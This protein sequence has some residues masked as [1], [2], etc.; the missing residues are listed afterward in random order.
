MT[1]TRSPSAAGQ[2]SASLTRKGRDDIVAAGPV[3]E[4]LPETTPARVV[5]GFS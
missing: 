3:G 2:S 5:G 1:P 4:S